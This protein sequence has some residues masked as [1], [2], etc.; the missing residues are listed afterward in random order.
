MKALFRDD[1]DQYVNETVTVT[2]SYHNTVWP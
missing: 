2:E 1:S